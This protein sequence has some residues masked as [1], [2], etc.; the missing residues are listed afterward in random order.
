MIGPLIPQSLGSIIPQSL[1]N[2]STKEVSIRRRLILM[3]RNKRYKNYITDE[4]KSH[5]DFYKEDKTVIPFDTKITGVVSSTEY[6]LGEKAGIRWLERAHENHYYNLDSYS[7]AW[8]IRKVRQKGF[9]DDKRVAHLSTDEKNKFLDDLVT[10]FW[11]KEIVVKATGTKYYYGGWYQKAELDH[12]TNP[13]VQFFGEC[14][15]QLVAEEL[16]GRYLKSLPAYADL[17]V[18]P[19]PAPIKPR[20]HIASKLF[21][22]SDDP[23]PR[24]GVLRAKAILER[25]KRERE[26]SAD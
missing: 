11:G 22:S 3:P 14:W 5:K 20:P 4:V 17:P 19:K 18:Q 26:T 7:P 25:R 13:E 2:G 6:Q 16:I 8:F 15:D 1:G 23:K 9:I 12:Y 24:E 21:E 10:R